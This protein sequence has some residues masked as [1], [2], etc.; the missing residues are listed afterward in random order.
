[1]KSQLLPV[2]DNITEVLLMILD[3]TRCRH[4]ILIE[5]LNNVNNKAYT[6]KDLDVKGFADVINSAL[7]EHLRS[8]RLALVDTD[9]VRFKDNGNFN[10][11]AV[12]DVSARDLFETDVE[13]YLE[14]QKKKL[15]E[16]SLNSRLAAELLRRK[17]SNN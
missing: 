3:F 15:S 17:Q 2:T 11:S 4:K 1:M 9:T 10:A 16:N 8:G 14:L 12:V 7:S 6:P 5:N 13:Q